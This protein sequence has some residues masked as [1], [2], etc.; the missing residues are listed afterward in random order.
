LSADLK[1]QY[2]FNGEE[3]LSDGTT[4]GDKL[5]AILKKRVD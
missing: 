3:K 4:K 5:R 2:N 1:K